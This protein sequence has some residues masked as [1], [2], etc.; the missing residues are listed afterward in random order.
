M[1]CVYLTDINE[2]VRYDGQVCA[3]NAE[4]QNT[5]GSYRCNCKDGF[6]EAADGRNCNGEWIAHPFF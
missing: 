6:T 1:L 4:C 3:L 5:E 2:C